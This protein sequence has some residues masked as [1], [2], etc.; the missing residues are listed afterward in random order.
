VR[1][2]VVPVSQAIIQD[3]MALIPEPRVPMWYNPE[4]EREEPNPADPD[5]LDALKAR[6]REQYR[7]T[8]DVFAAVWH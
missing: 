3:S 7:V 8:F 6:E 2:R 4:K 1:A 5:Y